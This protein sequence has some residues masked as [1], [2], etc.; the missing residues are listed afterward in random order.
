MI[1]LDTNVVSEPMKANGNP[2][3]RSW[4]DRQAAETVYLTA[5][6]LAELMLGIRI[7]PAGK[8]KK[9]L[10]M[11]LND[12]IVDLFGARILPFDRAAAMIYASLAGKARADGRALSMADGQIAAIATA[13]GFA[14]ATRD[15]APF[16]AAGVPIINPWERE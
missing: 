15:T 16:L 12:L 3:V 4:L 2:R 11:A 14:V 9:G 6:S 1:I 7:L 8:R 5:T 10:D 13:R